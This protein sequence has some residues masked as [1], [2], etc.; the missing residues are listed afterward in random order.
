MST[1]GWD[2]SIEKLLNNWSLQI[3][4]NE[5]EYRKRGTYYR[6]LY[7]GVGAF[8]V[9]TQTGALTTLVNVI[10]S[11]AASGTCDANA[12]VTWLLVVVAI[13]ET[14]VLVVQGID[15]FFN[16]GSGSELYYTAAKEHNAL[17]R[18]IS[19]TLSTSRANRGIAKDVIP[20]IRQQFDQIQNN[21]PNLPPNAVVHRLDM[22]IYKVPTEAKGR[23][24]SVS[25]SPTPENAKKVSLPENSADD[26]HDNDEEYVSNT[27]QCKIGAQLQEHKANAEKDQQ[28][29]RILRNLEYQW[30]RFAQHDEES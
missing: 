30:H 19:E 8:I 5:D 15:K 13:M 20:S 24:V 23:G 25:N 10:I 18:L 7:Y 21:S 4:I 11:V 29:N 14:L 1:N 28:S 12:V 16:F 3:S 22:Y 6:R 27:Q 17:N 2:K 26:T 9:T